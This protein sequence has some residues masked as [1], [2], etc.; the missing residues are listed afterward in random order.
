MNSREKE[1]RLKE[2]LLKDGN[3][4]LAYL[5][6]SAT[7]DIEWEGS[8][9][10][11]AVLMRDSSWARVS[12]LMDRIAEALDVSVDKIDLV[13]LSKADEILKYQVIS[14]GRLLVDRGLESKFMEDL[15]STFFDTTMF[16][17]CYAKNSL[18]PLRRE[19]LEQKIMFLDEEVN[20]L[21]RY[22]LSGDLTQ[23]AGD[24]IARRVLRDSLRVAIESA[25]DICKHIAASEKLGLIKEYKDFPLKLA[26][27][28]FLSRE[29]AS[30]LVDFAKLRNIIVHRY[31]ELDYKLLY[32]KARELVEFA[33]IFRREI[34]QLIKGREV[35]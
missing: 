31:I 5:F 15:Y 8:D 1:E 28:G 29:L 7:G 34:M 14:E 35:K 26:E 12:E 21:K 22:I 3:V 32:E 11:V 2:E 6:G 9:I 17:N 16:L 30:K 23:V 4:L 13:D 20:I 25:V 10:D 19:I 24:E 33:E 27:A 18:N